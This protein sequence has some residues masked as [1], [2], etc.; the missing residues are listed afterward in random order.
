MVA[1]SP[2]NSNH[3]TI[4]ITGAVQ[5]DCTRQHQPFS[6]K[7]FA[8]SVRQIHADTGL[9]PSKP[10]TTTCPASW[11][12]AC[13]RSHT[14]GFNPSFPVQRACPG[15]HVGHDWALSITAMRPA[16]T[17]LKS[18]DGPSRARH[19][20]QHCHDTRSIDRVQVDVCII[21]TNL[22]SVGNQTR[23][24]SGDELVTLIR[25]HPKRSRLRA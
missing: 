18:H 19:L 2:A 10:A 11:T 22:E 3:S 25:K 13:R 5:P 7:R 8:L 24:L 6:N 16:V 15:L 17:V 9:Y 23:Q 21:W 20:C 4:M 1:T 14:Q 12:A